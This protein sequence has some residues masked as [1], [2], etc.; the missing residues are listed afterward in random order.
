MRKK[1]RRVPIARFGLEP[2]AL[3]PN[4]SYLMQ[5]KIASVAKEI[6][7]ELVT[8]DRYGFDS[9]LIDCPI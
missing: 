1:A 8:E 3:E 9:R 6:L 5:R 4:H 2:G 7:H